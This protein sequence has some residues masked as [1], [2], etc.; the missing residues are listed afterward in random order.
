M[1]P[2]RRRCYR[3][4][5]VVWPIQSLTVAIEKIIIGEVL[6]HPQFAQVI[7]DIGPGQAINLLVAYLRQ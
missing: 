5:P 4:L 2:H 3:S 1:T 6:H 7:N